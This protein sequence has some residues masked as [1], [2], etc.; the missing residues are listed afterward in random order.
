M[1]YVANGVKFIVRAVGCVGVVGAGGTSR[2]V[3]S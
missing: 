2:S 3:G 1:V